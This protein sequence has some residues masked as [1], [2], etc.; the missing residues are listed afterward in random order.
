MGKKQT[1]LGH[2]DSRGLFPVL[3]AIYHGSW[4]GALRLKAD[5]RNAV[6][7]LIKG[8]VAHALWI[9]GKERIEGIEALEKAA[10]WREGTFLLDYGVLPPARTIRLAMSEILA[11]LRAGCD[12]TEAPPQGE[13]E[14]AE[15]LVS[16][17]AT[18]RERVPGLESLSVLNGTLVE[19]TTAH[20]LRE[21]GW[22][23]EQLKA[24]CDDDAIK[25]EKLFLQQGEHSLLILKRGQ[26]AAVLSARTGT[27][28]EALFWAGEEARKRV[29]VSD[30]TE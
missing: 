7:W 14:G 12:T 1:T 8:Q 26:F 16:V 21:R 19:A 10:A 2:L 30:V 11:M 27:A 3:Q 23:S 13:E 25:P 29:L 5:G 18:L 4:S 22:L 24:Y 28:P 6:L 15:E 20:E 9:K 17:L